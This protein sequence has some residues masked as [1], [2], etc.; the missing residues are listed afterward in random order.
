LSDCNENEAY[1][2]AKEGKNGLLYF[3]AAGTISLDLKKQSGKLRWNYLIYKRLN[4]GR[5]VLLKEE[6]WQLYHQAFNPK[7][8]Y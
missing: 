4:G 2:A 1:L 5:V 7:A 6:R 3:T 8:L